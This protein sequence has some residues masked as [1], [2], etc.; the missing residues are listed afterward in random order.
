MKMEEMLLRIAK[1][2]KMN[3][4]SNEEFL[5]NP[6][7]YIHMAMVQMGKVEPNQ[8]VVMK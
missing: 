6:N 7:K 1:V 2:L 3:G 4:V 5:R 8:K